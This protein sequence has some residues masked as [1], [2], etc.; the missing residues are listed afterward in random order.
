MI[1][2]PTRLKT[3]RSRR[4]LHLTIRVEGVGPLHLSFTPLSGQGSVLYSGDPR[5]QEA[6]EA[7]PWFG[8]LFYVDV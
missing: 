2:T 1:I 4:Q 8:Q 7:H 5:I 6:L 3:Y